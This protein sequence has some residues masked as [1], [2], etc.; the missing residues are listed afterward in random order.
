MKKHYIRITMIIEVLILVM[1]VL[2]GVFFTYVTANA[3]MKEHMKYA[4]NDITFSLPAQ[5]TDS[6]ETLI[7]DV[8]M[9]HWGMIVDIPRRD[10]GYYGRLDLSDDYSFDTSKTYCVVSNSEDSFLSDEDLRICTLNPELFDF[11]RIY[12]PEIDSECD[13]I[14]IYGGK[15]NDNGKICELGDISYRESER[16]PVS[17]WANGQ[18][19]YCT[20]VNFAENKQKEKLNIEAQKIGE[21]LI[22]EFLNGKGPETEKENLLTSY[23]FNYHGTYAG[24]LYDIYVFHPIQLAVKKHI[25]TYV[26]LFIALMAIEVIIAFVF[27]KLYKNRNEYEMRSSRL[28]RGIAHELKTPLAVTKAYMENW[29]Y[30][31]EED[32]PE[33]AEKI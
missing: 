25:T 7:K 18:Y 26:I 19:L 8:T 15:L 1:F 2:G 13:N 27:A 32:R 20:I 21:G 10:M 12:D 9:W 17:E 33:Y 5:T 28:K 14:F 22:E 24:I 31:D 3:E 30:I 11:D 16:I 4:K 29:E 6:E 23:Y